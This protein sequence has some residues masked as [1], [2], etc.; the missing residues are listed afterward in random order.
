MAYGERPNWPN[1][2]I[3]IVAPDI[4]VRSPNLDPTRLDRQDYLGLAAS[5][6]KYPKII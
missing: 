2:Y 1:S 4:G 3:R 6:K 5:A